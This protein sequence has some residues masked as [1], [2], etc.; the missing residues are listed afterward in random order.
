MGNSKQAASNI[1]SAEFYTSR[2]PVQCEMCF[3]NYGQTGSAVVHNITCKKSKKWFEYAKKNGW[4]PAPKKPT[5]DP[6]RLAG[7][8]KASAIMVPRMPTVEWTRRGT[9]GQARQS[10]VRLGA[11]KDQVHLPLINRVCSMSDASFAP[12]WWVKQLLDVWGDYCF[13]N[14]SIRA[15][16]LKPGYIK[17]DRFNRVVVTANPGHQTLPSVKP[18][19][20]AGGIPVTELY[21]SMGKRGD[22]DFLSPLT[23]TNIGLGEH[24]GLVKFYRL[25]ALPTIQG[26]LETDAPVVITQMRFLGA[27]AIFEFA[28]KYGLRCEIQ[29]QHG[30]DGAKDAQYYESKHRGLVQLIERR[31]PTAIRMWDPRRSDDNVSPNRG[32]PSEFRISHSW[33]RVAPG[34]FP[35]QPWVCD[36]AHQSCKACG[37]CATLDG[38]QKG[39]TNQFN[40]AQSGSGHEFVVAPVPDADYYL[41]LVDDELDGGDYFAGLFEHATGQTWYDV[42]WV[43]NAGQANVAP[44]DQ[45]AKMLGRCA[46]YLGQ[47]EP[48]HESWDTHETVL[49]LTGYCVWALVAHAKRRG[50]SPEAAGPAILAFIDEATGGI[51]VLSGVAGLDEIWAGTSPW[52]EQFGGAE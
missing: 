35:H 12:E 10:F 13:F 45:I 52:C 46:E 19:H 3:N 36:R 23:L 2:C 6:S 43:R 16:Q 47:C 44:E 15:L 26:R 11:G 18:P 33:Y 8:S 4:K 34:Q 9:E 48:V 32:E 28:R 1:T 41:P 20:A 21:G 38:T 17:A 14:S 31:G 5:D 39:Q 22:G 50:L 49:G 42:G 51:D 40:V 29:T 30:S 27:A 25:R 24:E 7:Y 37:L